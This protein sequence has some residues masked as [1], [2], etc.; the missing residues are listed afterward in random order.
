MAR[1][2]R[3]VSILV[4]YCPFRSGLVRSGRIRSSR[5][6]SGRV[7]SG[8]IVSVR[9]EAGRVA[10][11][12]VSIRLIKSGQVFANVILL[13]LLTRLTAGSVESGRPDGIKI[14][15]II[16]VTDPIRSSV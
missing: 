8:R 14:Y 16:D 2:G 3:I 4:W 5:I 12:R 15:F 13:F 7:E 9:V 1:S 11:Y 6:R 10:V